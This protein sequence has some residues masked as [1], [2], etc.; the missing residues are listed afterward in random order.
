LI[1]VRAIKATLIA[2]A[3]AGAVLAATQAQRFEHVAG[4]L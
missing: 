2:F 4:N 3:S 1:P